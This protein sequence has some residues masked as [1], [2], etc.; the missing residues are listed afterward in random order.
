MSEKPSLR[1]KKSDGNIQQR[2]DVMTFCLI[3]NNQA[4]HM[5]TSKHHLKIA[6]MV[7]ASKP[8]L[9]YLLTGARSLYLQRFRSN[10]YSLNPFPMFDDAPPPTIYQAPGV[11]RSKRDVLQNLHGFTSQACGSSR[12]NHRR[13]RSFKV[14][15]GAETCLTYLILNPNTN[16]RILKL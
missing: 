14:S 7:G 4:A 5:P 6:P 12:G 13:A 10:R 11:N 3:T 16:R 1:K 8:S 2:C 15:G 9:C